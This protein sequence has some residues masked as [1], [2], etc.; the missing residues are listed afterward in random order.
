MGG[1]KSKVEG[2]WIFLSHSHRDLDKVRQIRDVLERKGHNPLIFFL[3]CLEDD[4]SE[5]PDLLRREIGA[6]TWFILC[7]SPNARSSKWVQEEVKM[8]KSLEGKVFEIV[9]LS[10]DLQ[11]ELHKLAAISKRATIFL[12]YADRDADIAQRVSVALTRADFRVFQDIDF[13][14]T[15]QSAIDES[16]ANGFVMLLLSLN[17]LLSDYCKEET[18]YALRKAHAS[19]QSNVIP[20][21]IKEASQV[22]AA[23]PLQLALINCFDLTKGDFKDRMAELIH[24]LKT[25][26]ME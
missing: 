10:K 9:D 26:Q 3:K 11:A 18:D 16:L 17:S 20:V 2:A 23:L 13:G 7:D 4:G 21:L 1:Q 12:S 8:I 5:L 14:R 24:S 25:R 22:L 19:Q 6:R 15:I